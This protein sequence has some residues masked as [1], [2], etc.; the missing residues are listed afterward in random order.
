MQTAGV[1][2]YIDKE[3]T[4][5]VSALNR[6]ELNTRQRHTHIKPGQAYTLEWGVSKTV[7]KVVDLGAV[8]YYQQQATANSG[9][10][11]SS[12][13]RVA[14]VGPE[15]NVAFPKPMLFA[16]LRY[17]YEFLAEN[18]AQGHTFALTLTKRF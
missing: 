10:P 4:W 16:S 17:D 5:A 6:Y 7:A 11:S 1:T 9:P 13:D 12:R 15:V 3:K 14:A 2:W 8:G 18:R